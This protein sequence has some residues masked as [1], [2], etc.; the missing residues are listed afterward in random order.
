MQWLVSKF[1]VIFLHTKI[2]KR[3]NQIILE[4]AETYTIS[5]VLRDSLFVIKIGN[6]Y[7]ALKNTRSDISST[8]QTGIRAT[9]TLPKCC[10]QRISIFIYTGKTVRD[11]DWIRSCFSF[12]T[13]SEWRLNYLLLCTFC[14]NCNQH[15]IR[16]TCA[17]FHSINS[18][19]GFFI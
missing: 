16:C 12:F 6:P 2:R 15:D 11:R 8:D 10:K 7:D 9:I 4:K 14:N 13:V 19:A 5:C 18:K 3:L 17:A 1:A